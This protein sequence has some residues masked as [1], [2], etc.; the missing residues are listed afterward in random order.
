M[1]NRSRDREARVP[2]L[3]HVISLTRRTTA[4][5]WAV[6]IAFDLGSLWFFE[7]HGLSNLYGDGIA[8]VEGA[9]RLFDS[10]TPGYAEIGSVWLPLQHLLAAPLAINDTLWRTGLAG[11]LISVA[12]FALTAWFLLRL[13]LEMN[14]SLPA[15]CVTLAFFLI[16]LNMLYAASTPLT[17]PLAI[18]WAVLV[19]YPLFRFQQSGRTST[20]VWAAIAA[21]FGTLTR[22]DGWYLLPFAALFV[23][24]CCRRDWKT[25]IGQ[26]LVFCLISGTGPILWFLHNAYRYH[27]PLQFYNGPYSAQAI[28]AHQIATTGF[29]YP[30]DGS[31]WLSAHYYLEDIKLVFGPWTL[32]FAALGVVAWILD[33]RLRGRRSATLLL[34]VPLVFYTQSMAYGS[35]AIY[36][37]T[38]SPHTYYNLRYGLEMAPAMALFPG[39]LLPQQR[40]RLKGAVIPGILCAILLLQ[41]IAM[42]WPGVRGI[43]LV[44]ESVLNTPCKTEA[45]QDV[46]Q[47]FRQHYDG[48][49]LL[50]ESGEWPCLMPDVGIPYRKTL[51]PRNRKYWRQLRFGASRWVGWIVWM[52]GDAVDNLMRAYPQAFSDFDLVAKESLP[53]HEELEIYRRRSP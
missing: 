19:V 50:L 35:V 36:V 21:F 18:F 25:R 52:R 12:A 33:R 5:L 23:F 41:A 44:E 2:P 51:G 32:T 29:H 45:E 7:S 34:L 37:P 48:Q 9:R 40:S 38:L 11:S 10:L 14:R 17:E 15:A 20:C 42:A 22:Y 1:S 6:I 24:F 3:A 28:Y 31:L 30:T 16:S 26:T 53:H 39:F 27:N 8:H 13:S 46:I 43:A 49:P 47:F 4:T